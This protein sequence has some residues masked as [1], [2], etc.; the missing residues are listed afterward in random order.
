MY[1]AACKAE[2]QLFNRDKMQGT[3]GSGERGRRACF[4][5]DPGSELRLGRRERRANSQ[6]TFFIFLIKYVATA[7]TTTTTPS[8]IIVYTGGTFLLVQH[9][10]IHR[11]SS[12]R[13]IVNTSYQKLPFGS[14]IHTW[15]GLADVIFTYYSILR[16]AQSKSLFYHQ[17][18]YIR[19]HTT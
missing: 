6:L 10:Y 5:C 2:F 17:P 7:P 14:Y 1:H 18:W 11:N 16:I 8:C 4:L 15:Y 3:N 13:S 12:G 19:K 9:I